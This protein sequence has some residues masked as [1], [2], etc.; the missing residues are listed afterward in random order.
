MSKENTRDA[1]ACSET[2]M[3]SENLSEN[4]HVENT[5][6]DCGDDI[7][8]IPRP[9]IPKLGDVGE[10]DLD[11]HS[12]DADTMLTLETDQSQTSI[13]KPNVESKL[14]QYSSKC[15]SCAMSVIQFFDFYG[16]ALTAAGIET[17]SIP[18]I[19]RMCVVLSISHLSDDDMLLL[20]SVGRSLCAVLQIRLSEC[21]HWSESIVEQFGNECS[22]SKND[23]IN[24]HSIMKEIQT[25]FQLTNSSDSKSS[26]RLFP[27]FRVDLITLLLHAATECET[28]RSIYDTWTE[29]LEVLQAKENDIQRL[30]AEIDEHDA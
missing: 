13:K 10:Q 28:L 12:D 14:P 21:Q 19:A 5:L 3:H 11:G 7:D 2:T 17:I 30:I 29:R 20:D 26:L 8:L 1:D 27:E 25:L 22:G 23:E 9:E 4:L 16:D 6:K 18:E 24:Q 15:F